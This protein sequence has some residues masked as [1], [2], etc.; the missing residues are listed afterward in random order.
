MDNKMK[1][2]KKQRKKKV[3]K[4]PQYTYGEKLEKVG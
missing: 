1:L 3:D 2:E 4:Y